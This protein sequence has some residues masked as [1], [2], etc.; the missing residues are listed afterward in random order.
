MG[1]M[2]IGLLIMFT[3]RSVIKSLQFFARQYSATLAMFEE[4]GIDVSSMVS[5]L[6]NEGKQK[7]RRIHYEQ[8]NDFRTCTA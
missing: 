4:A 1:T 5:S 7:L 6:I 8:I 2:K 3:E